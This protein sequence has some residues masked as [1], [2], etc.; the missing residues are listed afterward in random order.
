MNMSVHSVAFHEVGDWLS[1]YLS[2]E[3]KNILKLQQQN[4]ER[5]RVVS[6][7]KQR[8]MDAAKESSKKSGSSKHRDQSI[9]QKIKDLAGNVINA[10]TTLRLEVRFGRRVFEVKMS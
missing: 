6:V 9:F 2:N 1:E 10:S 5:P 3:R 7:T 4:E 8:E